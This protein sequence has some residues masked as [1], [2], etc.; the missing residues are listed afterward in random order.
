MPDVA[1]LQKGDEVLPNAN[2]YITT[3][4]GEQQDQFTVLM[5]AQL[6]Q[7]NYPGRRQYHRLRSLVGIIHKLAF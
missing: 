7:N 2:E 1:Q 5:T 6:M 4:D 3:I